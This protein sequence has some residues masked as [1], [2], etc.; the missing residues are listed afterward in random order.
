MVPLSNPSNDAK[1]RWNNAHYTQLKISVNPE[2]AASFKAACAAAGVSMASVIV[3]F[4]NEYSNTLSHDKPPTKVSSQS[5]PTDAFSTRKK[6]RVAVK[7]II[8][9]MEQ[10]ALAEECYR[11]R[12]PENLQGSQTYDAADQ[13]VAVMHEVIDLLSEVY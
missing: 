5:V 11:D 12:I 2:T 10:L 7:A 8:S 9:Q 3:K 6:R 1:Q 13:S 4:M